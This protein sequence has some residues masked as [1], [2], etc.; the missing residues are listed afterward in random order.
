[1][2]MADEDDRV[3]CTCLRE[4]GG[5]TLEDDEVLLFNYT[6]S[7]NRAV[8]SAVNH[9][10]VD[11]VL[12]KFAK[13]FNGTQFTKRSQTACEPGY[14]CRGGVRRPCAPGRYGDARR[15]TRP[16]CAGEC[17]AGF[18]CPEGTGVPTACPAG[19]YLPPP[20][21]V[22]TS[23][24]SCLP[25]APGMLLRLPLFLASE[26]GDGERLTWLLRAAGADVDGRDRDG[27]TVRER[28]ERERP[29]A[30]ALIADLG[31][32]LAT[33]KLPPGWLEAKDEKNRTFYWSART[34]ET[35]WA[36]PVAASAF[37]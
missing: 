36:R 30:K 37:A 25:C 14:W 4:P 22:G 3:A 35:R 17:S 34:K 12:A 33:P 5:R 32:A 27:R 29:E 8:C 23:V 6:K 9:S 11:E 2:T 1:M 19:T 16:G 26:G 18:Y 13:L 20:P 10:R 24:A 15:E 7:S 21:V 28:L 31:R